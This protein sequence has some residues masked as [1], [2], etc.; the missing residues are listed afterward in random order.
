MGGATWGASLA[1]PNI[2]QDLKHRTTRTGLCAIARPKASMIASSEAEVRVASQALVQ[3][4]IHMAAVE[5]SLKAGQDLLSDRH[6]L[7]FHSLHRRHCTKKVTVMKTI[8]YA[9]WP[10][11][12]SVSDRG[13]VALVG[14]PKA[15]VRRLGGI[16]RRIAD[17]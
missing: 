9:S 13:I 1:C 8:L 7:H 2:D 15:A 4:S 5:A 6:L 14:G 3:C 16:H 10:P 17:E 12:E 11:I